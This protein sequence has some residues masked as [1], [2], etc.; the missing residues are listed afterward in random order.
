MPGPDTSLT[1]LILALAYL[2]GSIP[3]AVLVCHSMGLADPRQQGSG[4][5][6]TTNVLRLGNRPAAVLT[7]LGDMLKGALAIALAQWAELDDTETGLC[8]LAVMLGHLYPL[9][10][11]MRGGK[12]MATLLGVCLAL[13]LPVGLIALASWLL[14]ALIGKTASMASIGTA[15]VTPL[16]TELLLPQQF[17][18]IVL[19]CLLLIM[20]HRDNI[21]RLLNGEERRL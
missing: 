3:T 9:F 11:R 16:A 5:P 18:I 17:T 14:L 12:G 1:A 8:G 15:V 10:G 7:L 13:S 6:G 21:R 19:M 4:N 2:L 20:R